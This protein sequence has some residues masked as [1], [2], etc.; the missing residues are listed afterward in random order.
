MTN[1]ECTPEYPI[2]NN[3]MDYPHDLINQIMDRQKD[4]YA[5]VFGDDVVVKNGDKLAQRFDNVD[6]EGKPYQ[7]ICDSEEM[8]QY[9]RSGFNLDK[10][11][12]RIVNTKEYKQGVRVETCRNPGKSCQKLE[13]M[14]SKTEC[15]QFYHYRTILAINPETNEPYKEQ[16]KLPSCC[17]CVILR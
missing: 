7:N 17:K 3:V 11:S 6:E 12:V 16:I 14:F 2:C 4:R 5:E 1:K 9:P 15:R 10:K 8:V 13:Q